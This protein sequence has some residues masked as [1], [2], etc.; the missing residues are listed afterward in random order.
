MRAVRA[1]QQ[2]GAVHAIAHITGGGLVDNPPR[3]LGPGQRLRLFDGSWPVP[4]L[5]RRIHEEAGVPLPELR[6][7]FNLGIG[8][9]LIVPPEGAAACR[10]ACEEAGEAVYDIGVIEVADD[11]TAEPQV[12]FS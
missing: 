9:V 5:M 7:T 2:A 1:A 10:R 3:V 12:I 6:R 4:P 11:G 8:M